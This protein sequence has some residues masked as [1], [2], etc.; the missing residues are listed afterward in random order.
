MKLL[1]L[2]F[3][4]LC[5]SVQADNSFE[6]KNTESL[7]EKFQRLEKNFEKSTVEQDQFSVVNTPQFK[8]KPGSLKRLV[9][10]SMACSEELDKFLDYGVKRGVDLDIFSFG[11]G[12]NQLFIS[13]G[14]S[15]QNAINIDLDTNQIIGVTLSGSYC[16]N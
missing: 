3:I 7:I 5:I 14:R 1:F 10:S 15:L 16:K 4:F 13:Y 9:E 12:F 2:P 11:R 8:V 6:F